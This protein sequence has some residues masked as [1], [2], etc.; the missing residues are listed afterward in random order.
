MNETPKCNEHSGCIA[1]L[2]AHEKNV[3]ELWK[4]MNGLRDKIYMRLNVVL[5]GVCAACILLAL[6]L[7]VKGK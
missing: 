6:N 7:L 3:A 5:G 1:R 2:D 4:H